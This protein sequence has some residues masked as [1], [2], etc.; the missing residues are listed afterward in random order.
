LNTVVFVFLGDIPASTQ[1][2]TI[3]QF[4]N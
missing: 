4:P 1:E 3:S 2:K